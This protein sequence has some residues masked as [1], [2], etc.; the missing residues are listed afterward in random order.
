VVAIHRTLACCWSHVACY[1]YF[2]YCRRNTCHPL[3]H[4]QRC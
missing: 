1:A 3:R 4:Q 2:G